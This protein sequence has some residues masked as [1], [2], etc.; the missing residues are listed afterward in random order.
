MP[1]YFGSLVHVMLLCRGLK[2]APTTSNGSQVGGEIS[3]SGSVLPFSIKF[4]SRKPFFRETAQREGG[5]D[6]RN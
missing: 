2:H 4:I 3:N 6:P 5:I 1:R